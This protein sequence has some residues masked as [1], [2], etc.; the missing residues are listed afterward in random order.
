MPD[1]GSLGLDQPLICLLGNFLQLTW[2]LCACFL[3]LEVG[4]DRK[5]TQ[6]IVT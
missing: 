4:E 5:V 1:S 6:R 3:I 2:P